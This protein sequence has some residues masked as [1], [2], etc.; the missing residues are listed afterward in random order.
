MYR[1]SI[2]WDITEVDRILQARSYT[3]V[4]YIN[5]SLHSTTTQHY[6]TVHSTTYCTALHST[7][8][9]TTQYYTVLHSTTQ[10]YTVLHGTTQYYTV[11]YVLYYVSW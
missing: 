10:Y 5:V 1:V 2:G 8:C 3:Y 6:Y 9:Y 11:Q 7:T 4:S